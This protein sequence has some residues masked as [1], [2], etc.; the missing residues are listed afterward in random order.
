M[1]SKFKDTIS[2]FDFVIRLTREVM[3]NM[4]FAKAKIIR[5]TADNGVCLA[6][7]LRH[8]AKIPFGELRLR[9]ER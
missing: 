3:D 8:S 4:R 5:A 6:S 2:L 1:E 9:S 7:C